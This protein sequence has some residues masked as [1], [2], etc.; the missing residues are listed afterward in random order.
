MMKSRRE[1]MASKSCCGPGT[2]KTGP[3]RGEK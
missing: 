3:E 1:A 2:E